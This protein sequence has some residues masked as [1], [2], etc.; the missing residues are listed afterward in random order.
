VLTKRQ[1]QRSCSGRELNG[2]KSKEINEMIEAE[3]KF[4]RDSKYCYS[5][6][7]KFDNNEDLYSYFDRLLKDYPQYDIDGEYRKEQ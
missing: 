1:S 6:F 3:F 4:N 7:K 5:I 2:N